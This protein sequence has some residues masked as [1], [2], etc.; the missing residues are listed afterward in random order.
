MAAQTKAERSKA[1]KKGAVTR[2]KNEAKRGGKDLK[3][4]AG[5]AVDAAKE[6]AEA[7]AGAASKAAKAVSKRVG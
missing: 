7:G 3:N 4:A 2:R 6:I 1:A 5:N